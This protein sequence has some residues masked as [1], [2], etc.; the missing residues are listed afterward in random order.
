MLNTIREVFIDGACNV[1]EIREFTSYAYDETGAR[2]VEP[3]EDFPAGT[4]V[5]GFVALGLSALGLSPSHD[6]DP[7]VPTNRNSYH[8]PS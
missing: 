4:I 2:K 3:Y 5:A 1:V 8:R 6:P 7:A